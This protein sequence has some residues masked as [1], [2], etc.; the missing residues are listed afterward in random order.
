M[1]NLRIIFVTA[2]LALFPAS[3]AFADANP[4]TSGPEVYSPVPQANDLF[5]RARELVKNSDPRSGG[6][7]L[8]CACRN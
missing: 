3:M 6:K 1:A 8:K 4:A 7:L 2:F 5:L